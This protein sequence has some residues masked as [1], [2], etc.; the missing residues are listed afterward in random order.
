[1]R[2]VAISIGQVVFLS[3]KPFSKHKGKWHSGQPD[4]SQTSGDT[5]GEFL[6][7]PLSDSRPTKKGPIF[8]FSEFKQSLS[9]VFQTTR[10]C[11]VPQNQRVTR[12]YHL[13]LHSQVA[14]PHTKPISEHHTISKEKKR[15]TER[16]QLKKK[17]STRHGIITISAK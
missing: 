2:T 15:R 6:Q 8:S 9:S 5:T 4:N 11:T 1:M 7:P 14:N 17:M 3:L 13:F 16:C 12:Q 10:K